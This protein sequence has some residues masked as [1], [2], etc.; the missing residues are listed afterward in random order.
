MTG[1]FRSVGAGIVIGSLRRKFGVFCRSIC[2]IGDFG[3]PGRYLARNYSIKRKKG[4]TEIRGEP[5]R[6]L[7]GTMTISNPK[8]DILAYHATK[9][10]VRITATGGTVWRNWVETEA[11]SRFLGFW[12]LAQKL[13]G[14]ARRTPGPIHLD[15]CSGH[16]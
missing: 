3:C 5:V 1:F 10:R 6:F 12:V 13:L 7:V 2:E 16:H 4:R 14:I 8:C 9:C 15:P 11:L